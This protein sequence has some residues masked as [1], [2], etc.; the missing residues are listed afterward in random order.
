MAV[1]FVGNVQEGQCLL[2]SG[3]LDSE[4]V[5]PDAENSHT[6]HLGASMLISYRTIERLGKLD[7]KLAQFVECL[8]CKFECLN[9]VPQNPHK[10]PSSCAFI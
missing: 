2:V 9:S 5:R 8:M 3:T 6:F 7:W 1:Q 10:K 4:I